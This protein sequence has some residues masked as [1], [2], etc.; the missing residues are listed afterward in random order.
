[1]SEGPVKTATPLILIV[2]DDP[3]MRF[4]LNQIMR[5]EGYK[6][7]EAENGEE[8]LACYVRL[9]PDIVLLDGMMPEMDGFEVCSRL[10]SLPGGD[11]TPVLMIT[12]LN[13]N[14]SVDM[15]FKSG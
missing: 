14:S 12:G 8:G 13:D 9:R 11:Q 7:F 3:D 2:D 1:M 10:Q 15:A 4:L 6:V 5:Q